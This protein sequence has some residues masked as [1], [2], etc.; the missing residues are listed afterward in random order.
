MPWLVLER[1][2]ILFTWNI[3]FSGGA[4]PGMT[5]KTKALKNI[6]IRLMP[7]TLSFITLMF[8]PSWAIHPG[9]GDLVI[10]MKVQVYTIERFDTS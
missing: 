7:Q 2:Q 6:Y 5:G 4:V 10:S 8:V 1:T 3:G 9:S